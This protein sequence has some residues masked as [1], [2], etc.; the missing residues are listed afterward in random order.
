MLTANTR[1]GIYLSGAYSVQL[2][3]L[4]NREIARGL[5]ISIVWFNRYPLRSYCGP[6]Q[7]WQENNISALGI[8]NVPYEYWQY[9]A[10][11]RAYGGRYPASSFDI[12]IRRP[13]TREMAS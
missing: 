4:I 1:F 7:F 2:R 9:A 13:A 11:C 6:P 5:P 10:E 8:A 3:D 12:N